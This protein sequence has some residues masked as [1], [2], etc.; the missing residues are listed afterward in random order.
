MSSTLK[1]LGLAAVAALALSGCTLPNGATID[2]PSL[3]A[4]QGSPDLK[5]GAVRLE[6]AVAKARSDIHAAAVDLQPQLQAAARVAVGLSSFGRNLIDQGVVNG[7]DAKVVKALALADKLAADPVLAT[8]AAGGVTPANGAVIAM[9][10][11][12]NVS[13]I[14]ALTGGKIAPLAA[15]AL[16]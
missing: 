13:T 16:L 11:L 7:S 9:Q 1:A 10:L 6:A 15:V 12:R 4:T 14:A 3:A 2:L 5:D 8:I